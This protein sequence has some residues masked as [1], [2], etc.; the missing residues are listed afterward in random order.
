MKGSNKDSKAVY[1]LKDIL[2]CFNFLFNDGLVQLM[3]IASFSFNLNFEE[4]ESI[5]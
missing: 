4:P 2:K 5:I 1:T 3:C